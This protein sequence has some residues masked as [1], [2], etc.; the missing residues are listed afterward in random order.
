MEENE[1]PKENIQKQNWKKDFPKQKMKTKN[2]T[3]KIP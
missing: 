2:K 3:Q 1:K